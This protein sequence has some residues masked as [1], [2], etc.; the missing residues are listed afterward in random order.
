MLWGGSK[1]I[2]GRSS[3]GARYGC[4][5][6]LAGRSTAARRCP[7]VSDH[8][9]QASWQDMVDCGVMVVC[10]AKCSVACTG[11]LSFD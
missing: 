3:L 2:T 8:D 11:S 1:D 9:K 5:R 7:L 4:L 6:N 10:T